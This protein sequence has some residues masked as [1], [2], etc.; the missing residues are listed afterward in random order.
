MTTESWDDLRAKQALAIEAV[1][2]IWYRWKTSGAPRDGLRWWGLSLIGSVRDDV[3][4]G[5]GVLLHDGRMVTAGVTW[6]DDDRD[7]RWFDRPPF[8]I[9]SFDLF[10]LAK[11][12]IPVYRKKL[13]ALSVLQLAKSSQP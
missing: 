7:G 3:G 10:Q 6:H 8:V 12:Q 2:L 11:E 5:V 4:P 13:T 1:G 9:A